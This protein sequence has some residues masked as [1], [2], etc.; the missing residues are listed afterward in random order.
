VT[1]HAE[2]DTATVDLAALA[3]EFQA[4]VQRWRDSTVETDSTSV[5]TDSTV[6]TDS[7][8]E[9]DSTGTDATEDIER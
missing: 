7:T 6:A 2:S 9:T 4:E 1:P 5:E 8:V 3:T